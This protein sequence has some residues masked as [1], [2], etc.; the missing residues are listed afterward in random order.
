MIGHI[1]ETLETAMD[2]I[3]LVCELDQEYASFAIA[4]PLPGTELYQ[5]CLDNNIPLPTWNDFGSV[6]TPPHT[7]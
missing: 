4:I 5:Y 3:H 7:A 1:G 6:N 2:T